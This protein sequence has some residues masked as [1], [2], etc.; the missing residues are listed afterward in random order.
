MLILKLYEIVQW[1]YFWERHLPTLRRQEPW[2][3][4]ELFSSLRQYVPME[5]LLSND[6]R[7]YDITA[8]ELRKALFWH[9]FPRGVLYS[10]P[11]CRGYFEPGRVGESAPFWLC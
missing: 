1:W 4:F 5:I 6:V 2:A 3:E 8:E 7:P 9:E 11:Q 10:E